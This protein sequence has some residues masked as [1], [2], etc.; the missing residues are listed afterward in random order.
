MKTF[1]LF[2]TAFGALL[3]AGIGFLLGMT[4]LGSGGLL[5]LSGWIVVAKFLQSKRIAGLLLFLSTA[6][7]VITIFQG[8]NIYAVLSALTLILIGWEFFH[9]ALTITT[10]PKEDQ[11]TFSKEHLWPVVV[12]GSAGIILSVLALHVQ[13]RLTFRLGLALGLAII[14]LFSLILRSSGGRKRKRKD[15]HR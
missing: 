7:A 12:L 4:A 15:R 2:F 8:G 11:Q 9:A 5:L 6:L 10:F 3:L 14:I 13:V 1:S